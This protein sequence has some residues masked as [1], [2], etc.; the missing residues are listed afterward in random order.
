MVLTT[1]RRLICAVDHSYPEIDISFPHAKPP[2]DSSGFQLKSK[3]E[4][5]PKWQI[6]QDVHCTYIHTAESNSSVLEEP[7]NICVMHAQNAAITLK[8]EEPPPRILPTYPKS[9]SVQSHRQNYAIFLPPLPCSNEVLSPL[10]RRCHQQG[11]KWSRHP[12]ALY[13]TTDK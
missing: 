13:R 2:P 7:T 1:W 6:R 8:P 11:T 3:L 4:S 10:P 9:V 5:S 12:Y